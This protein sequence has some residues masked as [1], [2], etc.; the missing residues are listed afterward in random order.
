MGRWEIITQASG[1]TDPMRINI[2]STISTSI[3]T[4][5]SS[6]IFEVADDTQKWLEHTYGKEWTVIIYESGRGQSAV[7]YFDKKFLRVKETSLGWSISLF[8]QTR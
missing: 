3:D 5:G 6:N 4:H 2:L 8:Q 1:I 7:N